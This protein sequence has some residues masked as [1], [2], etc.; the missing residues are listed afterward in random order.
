MAKQKLKNILFIQH[1]GYPVTNLAKA[2]L[3]RV[4]SNI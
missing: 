3:G 4:L 1:G 2:F